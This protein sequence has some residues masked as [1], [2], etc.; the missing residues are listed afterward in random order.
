MRKGEI[1][2]LAGILIL[3]LIAGGIATQK[4]YYSVASEQG[5]KNQPV[6]VPVVLD[7]ECVPNVLLRR[8]KNASDSTD[9]NCSWLFTDAVPQ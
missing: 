1:T 4:A 5:C 9:A 3:W 2:I 7:S 8:C 6:L